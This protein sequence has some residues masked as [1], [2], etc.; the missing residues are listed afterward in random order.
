MC[1][2]LFAVSVCITNV[3]PTAYVVV[4][5]ST[6][7]AAVNTWM[8][9]PAPGEAIKRY[10]VV[11]KFNTSAL[12]IETDVVIIPSTGGWGAPVRS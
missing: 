1:C 12:A 5:K 10:G 4:L 7:H 8:K 2:D 9:Y 3:V 6:L 11:P